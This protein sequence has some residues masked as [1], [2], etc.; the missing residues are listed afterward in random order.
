MPTPLKTGPGTRTFSGARGFFM[1]NGDVIGFASGCTGGEEIM[2]DDVVTL[3]HLEAREYVPVGYRVSFTANVFRTIARS[4]VATS[5]DSP[6]SLKEQNVFPHFDQILLLEGV[7]VAIVDGVTGKVIFMLTE[8]KCQ[9]YSFTV[10]AR[11]LVA[12][13]LSFNGIKAFDESEVKA[14]QP[15]VQAA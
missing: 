6:G 13:N 10:T 11:G 14:T 1:W 7:D 12:S 2:Y 8:V 9:S 5:G 4:D 3:G 15:I